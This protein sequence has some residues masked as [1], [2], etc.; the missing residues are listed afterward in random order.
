MKSAFINSLPKAGTNLLAKCLQLFGYEE[1]GHLGAGRLID[2]R[3]LYAARR[4]LWR[5]RRQGYL[6]GVDSPIEVAR[7]PVDR[8][9]RRVAS[10]DGGFMTAHVGYTLDLVHR[11]EAAGVA[12]ILMLRDPRAVLASFVPY[13]MK[14]RTHSVHAAL[15]ALGDE[16][17]YAAALTGFFG[18]RA[19]L[20][21]LSVRCQALE[22]WRR[23]ERVLT[24]RFEDIIGPEGGGSA[25][26][27]RATLERLCERLDI[28]AS[29]IDAV[30]R[31]LF[32]PGRATFRKG[33]IDSWKTEIPESVQG[34]FAEE[35]GDILE[36][37]E[38]N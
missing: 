17:R 37:W 27:R 9:I 14:Q 38:Y 33:R 28:D 22:C 12:P 18:G 13:V 36:A 35:I 20:Q 10:R 31:D 5:P 30:A 6:I 26:A 34:R 3:W 1:R 16:E 11:V 32:G 25:E 15:A 19:T 4:V 23:S 21:P 8:M 7:R 2:R 29:R 24:V